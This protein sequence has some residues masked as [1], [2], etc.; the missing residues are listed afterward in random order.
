MPKFVNQCLKYLVL[1][2]I[3]L[4]QQTFIMQSPDNRPSAIVDL[5][6]VFRVLVVLSDLPLYRLLLVMSKR[7]E[8]LA[9]L[10]EIDERVAANSKVSFLAL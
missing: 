6:Q 5:N 3:N 9:G 8:L 10:K 7:S 1:A 4:P 2:F